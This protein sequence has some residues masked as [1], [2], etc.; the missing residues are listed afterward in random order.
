MHIPLNEDGSK[1]A[2]SSAVASTAGIIRYDL[3]TLS[4]SV[5]KAWKYSSNDTSNADAIGANVTNDIEGAAGWTKHFTNDG[6]LTYNTSYIE[7]GNGDFESGGGYSNWSLVVHITPDNTPTHDEYIIS[8]EGEYD[9]WLDT[10]G[11]VNARIYQSNGVEAAA[12][13]TI[14]PIE[15]RGTA[16]I[17]L[18]GDTPTSVIITVDTNLRSNNAK[19]YLNGKLED[20]TGLALDSGT[21]NNWQIDSKIANTT[22]N[23]NIGRRN[24]GTLSPT[25]EKNAFDGKI[26]EIVL[27]ETTL[28]PISPAN[29]KYTFN[30]L[31]NEL[32]SSTSAASKSYVARL[33][34]KDYHNIRGKTRDT[35]CASGQLSFKKAGFALDTS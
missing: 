9:V 29:N 19:L 3:F 23:F 27:Y 18:D 17:P 20:Q 21:V 1:T 28:H 25:T 31:H 24:Y 15:L 10:S 13:V 6:T 7:F 33:F 11:Q 14:P 35:V 4:A 26:E 30:P 16:V 2:A 34:M 8:K 22:T 32:T 5:I 12:N